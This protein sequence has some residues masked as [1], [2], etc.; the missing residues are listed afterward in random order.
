MMTDNTNV[1]NQEMDTD[2]AIPQSVL[3]YAKTENSFFRVIDELVA[4]NL[5]FRSLLPEGT[6]ESMTASQFAY[7]FCTVHVNIGRGTGKTEYMK[8][9]L[10]EGVVVVVHD[11]RTR[12]RLLKETKGANGAYIVNGGNANP[13]AFGADLS[14]RRPTFIIIDEPH[15]ISDEVIETIY[16]IVAR[17]DMEQVFILLGE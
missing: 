15:L 7:D 5:S 14:I 12:M 9:T 6:R 1:L 3:E 17:R 13:V 8:R 4:L 16:N 10:F 11:N 2:R